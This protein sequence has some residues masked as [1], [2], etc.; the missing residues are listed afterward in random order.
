MKKYI[1]ILLV[2]CVVS[3]GFS[4]TVLT[5]KEKVFSP[6]FQKLMKYKLAEKM[7]LPMCILPAS[8][9]NM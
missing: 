4:Q 3:F 6:Q 2:L 5:P 1:T 9:Q 7:D 8:F